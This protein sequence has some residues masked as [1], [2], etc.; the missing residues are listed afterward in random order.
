[1]GMVTQTEP[2]TF[3]T[4]STIYR[5]EKGSN[6][7]TSVRKDLYTAMANLLAAQ[8]KECERIAASN[9]DS[10]MYDGAIERK[11]K[12]SMHIK[13]IIEMRTGKILDLAK[14]G[15]MGS[16]VA[17]DSMTAEEREFYQAIV[18]AARKHIAL[19]QGKKKTIIPDVTNPTAPIVPEVKE[20]EPVTVTTVDLPIREEPVIEEEPAPEIVEEIP[21]NEEVIP[22][23][24]F[25]IDD[26]P[27]EEEIP[28]IMEEEQFPEDIVQEEVE[29]PQIKPVELPENGLVTIRILEDLPPFSGPDR[30]YILVKEDVVRMP[31]MMAAALVNRG[32]AS[33]IL[34]S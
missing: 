22:M 16:N 15:A 27:P 14:T 33:V 32:K 10:V 5:Q 23:D 31:S 20:P 3:D 28:E 34:T 30:D 25:P 9:I 17:V 7:L 18:E 6:T 21:V 2:M 13:N 8:K 26:F 24:D 1:M 29:E 12:I 4:L 19:A 11:K